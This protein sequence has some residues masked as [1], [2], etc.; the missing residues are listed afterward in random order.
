[1]TFLISVLKFLNQISQYKIL[2]AHINLVKYKFS[3]IKP[4]MPD[5]KITS[6]EHPETHIL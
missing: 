4:P 2:K 3:K 6:S 1:V 5:L